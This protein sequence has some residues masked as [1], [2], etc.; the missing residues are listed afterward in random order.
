MLRRVC[1]FALL[2]LCLCT[3]AGAAPGEPAKTAAAAPAEAPSA[4]FDSQ[5]APPGAAAF[6]AW[7]QPAQNPSQLLP[8]GKAKAPSDPSAPV[9]LSCS[10]QCWAIRQQ[11]VADCN[12]DSSC[13]HS[14][15]D[16]YTC[17]V[18]ACEGYFCP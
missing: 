6:L 18:W 3:L 13:V 11:C 7:L 17:C 10:S 8:K 14:C 9:L 1:L 16:D 4:A 12:G 2:T 15:A 5:A